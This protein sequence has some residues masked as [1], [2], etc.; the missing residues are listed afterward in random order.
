VETVSEGV[1]AVMFVMEHRPALV[2]LDM[3]LAVLDGVEVARRL[4]GSDVVIPIV[5]FSREP[6]EAL[7]AQAGAVGVAAVVGKPITPLLFQRA[8]RQASAPSTSGP[9]TPTVE[10]TPD[11]PSGER[12]RL[13]ANRQM[14]EALR[15]M[16]A[17]VELHGHALDTAIAKQD[18]GLAA[19]VTRALRAAVI[20]LNARG[21]EAV[22][23][24]LEQAA[25]A[26]DLEE[27]RRAHRSWHVALASLREN[28]ERFLVRQVRTS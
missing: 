26:G 19:E 28:I 2:V 6:S 3:A 17:A 14:D 4:R 1:A 8:L 20:T 27:C 7:S 24:D 18:L 13:A 10:T 16:I 15:A 12:S 23:R 11:D 22:L 25:R 5:G 9:R 21:L